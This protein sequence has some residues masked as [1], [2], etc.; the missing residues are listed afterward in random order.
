[1]LFLP[2]LGIATLVLVGGWILIAIGI[3]TFFTLPPKKSAAVEAPS[4]TAAA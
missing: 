2:A 1:M 4:E 3:A